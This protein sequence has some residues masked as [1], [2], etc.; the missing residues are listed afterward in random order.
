VT[1]Y[2]EQ[3]TLYARQRWEIA[4][5]LVILGA[6]LLG[7]RAVAFPEQHTPWFYVASTVFYGSIAILAIRAVFGMM[8][9]AKERRT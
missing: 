3:L 5:L 4:F 9:R 2:A 6:G 1:T 7:F 8:S